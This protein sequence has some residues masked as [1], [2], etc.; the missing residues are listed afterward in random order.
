MNPVATI[1]TKTLRTIIDSPSIFGRP[2]S[3]TT[4]AKSCRNGPFRSTAARRYNHKQCPVRWNGKFGLERSCAPPAKS[5]AK[6]PFLTCYDFT[7]AQLMQEAGVPG[8]LVGDSAANVILGHP[9]PLPVSLSFMI[10]ITAA[11]RRGAPL[12]L[13]MARYALRL[14]PGLG[15]LWRA[16][17]VPHGETFRLRLCED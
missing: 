9:T 16:K 10:E 4:R 11:V 6:V 5:G 15:C 7:T 8:L 17:C 1:E 2:K 12:A 3:A 14:V 13:L